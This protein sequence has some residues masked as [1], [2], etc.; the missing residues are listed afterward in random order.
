MLK[1]YGRRK[2]ILLHLNDG[3]LFQ[4]NH[5][6]F[7]NLEGDGAVIHLF[8]KSVQPGVRDHLVP[9]LQGRDARLLFLLGLSL[10]ADQHH[11]EQ[12]DDDHKHE[13]GAAENL[14][15][16]IGGFLSG[17]GRRILSLC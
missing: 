4:F 8:H 5:H 2:T 9:A 15:E 14:L 7:R 12:D 1:T 16:H 17:G 11:P 3:V 6:A 10:G 13:H